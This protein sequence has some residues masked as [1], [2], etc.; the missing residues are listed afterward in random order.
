MPGSGAFGGAGGG[1]PGLPPRRNPVQQ[2]QQPSAPQ[3]GGYSQ[4][5]SQPTQGYSAG[6]YEKAQAG[7]GGGGG[8]VPGQMP[9]AARHGSKFEV[10][11]TPVDSYVLYNV[12]TSCILVGP[13]PS[14]APAD[15]TCDLRDVSGCAPVPSPP[16]PLCWPILDVHT[17]RRALSDT[18]QRLIVSPS[19]FDAARTP[20]VSLATSRGS[21]NFAILADQQVRPGTV[22]L[23][24]DYRNWVYVRQQGDFVDVDPLDVDRETG[25]KSYLQT[26]TL[27]VGQAGL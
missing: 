10:V 11:G 21:F 13:R 17:R 7:G 23:G 9:Q 5:S 24:K 2:Q 4:Y 26:V 19:D 3:G 18:S 6:G 22:C 16:G 12:S 25:G 20:F 14:P 1:G 15:P 27:E 8:G